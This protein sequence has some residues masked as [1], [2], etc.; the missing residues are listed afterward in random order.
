MKHLYNQGNNVSITPRAST[1]PLSTILAS[2]RLIFAR[3]SLCFPKFYINET[4]QYVFFL[5][6]GLFQSE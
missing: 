4:R 5:Y 1:T 3:S 6:P 2:N